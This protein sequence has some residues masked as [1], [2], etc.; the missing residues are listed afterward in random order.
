MTHSTTTPSGATPSS[1]TPAGATPAGTDQPGA[2]EPGGPSRYTFNNA[3]E[4]GPIQ[5]R[6]LSEV[7]DGHSTQV[8]DDTGVAAGWH[9]LDVGPGG[10]SIVDWL[11]RRVGPSGHVTA[12]DLDPRHLHGGDNITIQRGDVRTV[13]L[14]PD[15]YDLIHLRL[16]LVHLAEREQVLR[17]LIS[18]L[19]PG[20]VIVASDWD[21]TDW[22]WVLRSPSPES[23]AAF[24]AF[25]KGL[26]EVL[27]RN[28]ADMTWARRAPMS[29]RDAGLELVSTSLYNRVW[30]GGESGCLV[31]STNAD[32]MR[33]ALL[34]NGMT[35]RELTLLE[36]AMYDPDTL[37]Y[38][39]TMFTT[40][41]RRPLR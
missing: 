29:M 10:G 7:L 40:V 3:T 23:T 16:V 34:A 24:V 20:G 6:L 17:R 35:T 37:I 28:G 11:A 9:C 32:Q 19:K 36:E 41:G 33:E 18:A 26:F 38:C 39:Y 22:D 2:D 5:L 25:Q 12:L 14:P 27:G 31:H 21:S 13:D 15:H 30:A 1:A 8:L 4:Q